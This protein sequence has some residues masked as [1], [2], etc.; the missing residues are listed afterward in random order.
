M[1]D[2]DTSR[3]VRP[4]MVDKSTFA[5]ERLHSTI[6]AKNH[7]DLRQL[8]AEST[9]DVNYEH[10]SWG[11]PLHNA[12][13][14]N[15]VPAIVMLLDAGADPLL[16][17]EKG[18]TS[19]SAVMLAAQRGHDE[20]FGVLWLRVPPEIHA[21]H[22]LTSCLVQAA[23]YGHVFLVG[24]LLDVW[25]GWTKQTKES[26]LL[27]AVSRWQYYVVNLLLEKVTFEQDLLYKA[28]YR[29]VDLKSDFLDE[30]M[31]PQYDGVDYLNQQRMITRLTKVGLDPNKVLNS[32][33]LVHIA[34]TYIDLAGALHVLLEN[35]ADPNVRDSQG[36]TVMHKLADRTRVRTMRSG[37]RIH[38][39][40]IY[41]CVEHGASVTVEDNNGE[42][43]IH[44]VMY[45][46][47]NMSLK[48]YLAYARNEDKQLA[49]TNKHGETLLHYAASDAREDIISYIF[50]ANSY[51]AYINARNV[52][53]WTPLICALAPTDERF[54][55]EKKTA[56]K[57]LLV[58]RML[59]ERGADPGIAT[60][61]GLTSLHCL[62][63]YTCADGAAS[64]DIAALAEEFIS[65]GVLPDSPA[66]ILAYDWQQRVEGHGSPSNPL[67]HDRRPWGS[68]LLYVLENMSQN[69]VIRGRTPLHCAAEV[70][71]VSVAKVLLKHGADVFALDESGSTPLKCVSQSLKLRGM[72]EIRDEMARLLEEAEVEGSRVLGENLMPVMW[73]PS[74]P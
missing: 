50:S 59:L 54:A 31:G 8:L 3:R 70:G 56:F 11:T 42:M 52:N 6:Y 7:A 71:A 37:F 22:P 20:A 65:R 61:E 40:G 16:M 23:I 13:R 35:G 9:A 74:Q 2:S 45:G 68:R 30:V 55:A 38:E 43:P 58:G 29:A 47:N 4:R 34:A 60:D 36:R 73:F 27:H 63:M 33:P 25:D 48:L 21:N 15:D 24:W 41:M 53:G 46:S 64:A 69:A 67:F 1:G 62:A 26:A 12:I 66:T 51:D 49:C 32:R 10:Y 17:T 39:A 28:L 5:Q 44:L 72:P 14:Q 57:G 18:E 19:Y